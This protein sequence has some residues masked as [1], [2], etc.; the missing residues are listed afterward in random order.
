MK[1]SEMKVGQSLYTQLSSTALAVLSRRADGYS[2]YVAGV[3]GEDHNEEWQEVLRSGD[4]QR[5]VVAEAILTSLFHPAF[6]IDVPYA[7]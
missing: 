3:P 5:R 1:L 4:K 6:E 2:V 7:L